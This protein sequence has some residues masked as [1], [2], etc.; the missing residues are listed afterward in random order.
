MGTMT[1]HASPHAAL[2]AAIQHSFAGLKHPD[3]VRVC[4][5]EAYWHQRAIDAVLRLISFGGQDRY[6][7][8]YVTTFGYLIFVPANFANR[9]PI[10]QQ[11]V[12]QHEL[13]HVRQFERLGWIGMTLIYGLFPLPVGFAY[14]RARLEWEAYRETIRATQELLGEAAAHD[15]AFQRDI[16]RRFVGPDYL[17]MWPF[18]KVVQ[19]WINLEL[20]RTDIPRAPL[21]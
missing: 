9:S 17:W 7:S 15:A 21:A 1:A 18:P 10:E 16:L 4:T 12:L 8:Q 13:V 5:K 20:T 6:L 2:R 14:G 11:I 3:R 19:R